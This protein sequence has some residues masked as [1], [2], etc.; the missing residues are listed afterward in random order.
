MEK[1]NDFN[2]RVGKWVEVKTE[3]KGKKGSEVGMVLMRANS[4]AN[5]MYAFSMK[6][7]PWRSST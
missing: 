3:R 4:M 5:D 6:L 1:T 2:R 7:L